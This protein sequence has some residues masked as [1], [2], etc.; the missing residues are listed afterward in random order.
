MRG[1]LH[2]RTIIIPMLPAL[3]FM[4]LMTACTDM[5]GSKDGTLPQACLPLSNIDG[6]GG[7][8]FTS[9][10]RLYVYDAKNGSVSEIDEVAGAKHF[11][12]LSPDRTAAAYLY[13][14]RSED[15]FQTAEKIGIYEMAS[16]RKTELALE[17]TMDQLMKVYWISDRTIMAISHLN[18]S[19]DIYQ[20]FDAREGRCLF[21]RPVGRLYDVS[22]DGTRIIYYFTQHF[23]E[24]LLPPHLRVS[25]VA[26][27]DPG[28]AAGFDEP[29]YE[30]RD[31]DDR[32]EQA[33]FAGGDRV[34]FIEY[35]SEAA[36]YK[37]KE[38][39]IKDDSLAVISEAPFD[40][41]GLDAENII[42]MEYFEDR[43]R[44]YIISRYTG[45]RGTDGAGSSDTG[46]MDAGI[47]NAGDT[48]AESGSDGNPA[49]TAERTAMEDGIYLFEFLLRQDESEDMQP[50][51]V[52]MVLTG[53]DA[54]AGHDIAM[55]AAGDR[56]RVTD[57]TGVGTDV[58]KEHYIYDG[59]GF[60]A[61]LTDGG[62]SPGDLRELEEYAREVTGSASALKI[63]AIE[64]Y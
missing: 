1:L 32:I 61:I 57:I 59:N 50:V 42:A 35:V 30:V 39:E 31:G 27:G 11:L 6:C 45:N 40:F 15:A 46:S 29:V 20:A 8:V 12:G 58:R 51:C 62:V 23:A 38:A 13:S 22:R 7:A 4:L 43:Y 19:A 55:E 41:P 24:K 37:L 21:I 44:L 5:V 10:G 26:T 14:F 36:G 63:D 47:G 54:D 64:L 28:N 49:R 18:P 17:G 34:L 2:K 3:V 52:N 33:C 56:I 60:S 16:G 53:L 9:G 25:G 48:G